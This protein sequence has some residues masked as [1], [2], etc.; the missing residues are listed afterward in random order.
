MTFFAELK[1][2]NVLRIAAAYLVA[3]WLIVQVADVV[4]DPFGVDDSVQR[5]IIIVLAI[6]FVPVLVVA[7]VFELT[8]EGLVRDQGSSAVADPAGNKRFDR[9]IMLTLAAAVILFGVHTFVIDPA[10]DRAAIDAARSEG[11]V[12]ALRQSFGD[13]SIAVL[14][15]VN[16]SSDPEQEYFGDGIAEELLHLLE[17][18]PGLLVTSRTSSFKFKNTDLGVKEIADELGVVH[19]LEGSVRKSGNTLRITAQL[20]DSR[21]DT[22]LWSGTFDRELV[23]IFE[24][25]DEVAAKVVEE[26]KIEMNVGMPTIERHDPEAYM[27]Y[28]RARA[29]LSL[30]DPALLDDAQ[31]LINRALEIE[32]DYIDVQALRVTLFWMR[33]RQ[34]WS[35]G[36]EEKG[37]ELMEARNAMLEDLQVRAPENVR[38]QTRLAWDFMLSKNDKAS[39]AAQI[40]KGLAVSPNDTDLLLAAFTLAADLGRFD[41]AIAI[42]EYVVQRDPLIYWAHSNLADAYSRAGRRDEAIS[43]YRAAA[44]LSPNTSAAHWKLGAELLFAGRPEEAL[45]SM[46]RE[47]GDVYRLHGLAL[48]H[49]A[50]GDVEKS[51]ENLQALYAIPGEEEAWPFGFARAH[52]WLGDADETFRYLEVLANDRGL[53]SLVGIETNPYFQPIH[54]DP[55]WQPLVDAAKAAAPK[56][57]FDPP[58]PPEVHAKLQR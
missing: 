42:G 25:Q 39:A 26:L 10:A 23:D 13:K 51:S 44:S 36:D 33:A 17:K 55:R 16:M 34:A 24:I 58:L 29:H 1:R 8:P 27:L 35:A 12:A 52:A 31:K 45:N 56:I 48:A 21:L 38:V 19:V 47:V 2:R 54:D 20:I 4:L 50:L 5:I 49:H 14:P 18:V 9:I 53:E 7:W 32:P 28:L 46:Q 30:D 57:D 41:L 15:F 40:E 37:N 3:A 11:E 6:G 22:H 43:R